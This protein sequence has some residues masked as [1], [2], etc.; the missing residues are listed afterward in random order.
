MLKVSDHD[1]HFIHRI[2]P[3]LLQF[4]A[5]KLNAELIYLP[6]VT[7]SGEGNKHKANQRIL[8]NRLNKGMT[9]TRLLKIWQK[10][11]VTRSYAPAALNINKNGILYYHTRRERTKRGGRD[12]DDM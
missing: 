4:N 10:W 1:S 9:C 11:R 5:D 2:S 12:G 6:R 7:A 3:S 8:L